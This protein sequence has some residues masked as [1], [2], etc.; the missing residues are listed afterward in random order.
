MYTSAPSSLTPKQP[1]GL[2]IDLLIMCGL[3]SVLM[4]AVSAIALVSI[5]SVRDSARETV[6]VDGQLSQLASEVTTQSLESRRYEKDFFLN[7]ADPSMRSDYL[8]KWH[9]A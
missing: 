7:A 2:R 4:A 1:G 5:A 9:T 3:F 8:A 6:A